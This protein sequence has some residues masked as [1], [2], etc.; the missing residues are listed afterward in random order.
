MPYVKKKFEFQLIYD[1]YKTTYA[2]YIVL[3]FIL[4]ERSETK[5][6]VYFLKSACG[7]KI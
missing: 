2:L 4:I 1:Y 6:Y 7:G 5:L 3:Y